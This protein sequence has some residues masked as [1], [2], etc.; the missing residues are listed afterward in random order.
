MVSKSS[1]INNLNCIQQTTRLCLRSEEILVLFFRFVSFA[2]C[3]PLIIPLVLSSVEIIF[4]NSS[5]SYLDFGI[6]LV[7][8]LMYHHSS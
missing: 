7:F 4:G 2:H 3:V 1:P 8:H 6:S 5:Y